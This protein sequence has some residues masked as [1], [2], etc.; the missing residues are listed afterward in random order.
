VYVPCLKDEWQWVS[1]SQTAPSGIPG[2]LPEVISALPS[3]GLCLVDIIL[4]RYSWDH[5]GAHEED[6]R[7]EEELSTLGLRQGLLH[8]GSAWGNCAKTSRAEGGWEPLWLGG[9]HPPQAERTQVSLEGLTKS[10]LLWSEL[11][12]NIAVGPPR[13]GPGRIRSRR[14]L[15]GTPTAVD[16]GSLQVVRYETH[17]SLVHLGLSMHIDQLRQYRHPRRAGRICRAT[18]RDNDL[19]EVP[20]TDWET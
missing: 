15:L 17:S 10:A 16:P 5:N 3:M 2:D 9:E 1:L 20:P 4:P 19:P 13:S 12:K 11:P 14:L 7:G 8:R 6:N 18:A